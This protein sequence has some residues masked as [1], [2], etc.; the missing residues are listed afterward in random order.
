MSL[1]I[2][3]HPDHPEHPTDPLDSLEFNLRIYG[4]GK[5]PRS[6]CS[7][8]LDRHLSEDNN[9]PEDEE[10][11]SG[12]AQ[13]KGTSEDEQEP[14]DAH[15]RYHFQFGG[16]HMS[17]EKYGNALLLGSPRLAHPPLDAVLGVDFVLAN[18]RGAEWRK[19]L[20]E[21]P[22]YQRILG[23][24]QRRFWRPYIQSIGACWANDRFPREAWDPR[25]VWPSM[26]L[27]AA[28]VQ[29]KR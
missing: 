1:A 7:W 17:D 16:R 19:L 8:H 10:E 18:F 27:P 9:E 13:A 24:S 22:N 12:K 26:M 28:F 11:E 6:H 15:P 5:E 23:N 14:G 20:S 29:G 4:D 2:S 21:N 25:D 3:G